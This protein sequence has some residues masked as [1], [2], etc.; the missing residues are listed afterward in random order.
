MPHSTI[1]DESDHLATQLLC[2]LS[3]S[4]YDDSPRNRVSYLACSV[5]LEHWQAARTLLR[6]GLLPSG[7]VV[8]RA[9]YEALVRAIWAF[10][11]ATESQIEKLAAVLTTDSEQS[12]KNLP[13]IADMLAALAT[14]APLQPYQALSRFRDTSWKA[15]NSYAHAGIH[16]LQR[17][18]NGYPLQLIEQVTRNSNGLA[19][20]SGMQ[21]AVLTGRQ[22]HVRDVSTLQH[23]HQGC[24]PA[25]NDA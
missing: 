23:S 21:A 5:S 16:P 13:L 1:F 20:I 3:V 6:E 12:A 19:V 14:K 10:Y 8:H 18:D 7:L 15:L 25:R 11:A 9:Q 4:G 24:L 17:H 22:Q 2:V